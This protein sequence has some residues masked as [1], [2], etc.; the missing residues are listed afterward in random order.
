MKESILE[1]AR[2]WVIDADAPTLLDAAGSAAVLLVAAV[3][4]VGACVIGLLLF[5]REA[6]RVAEEL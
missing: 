5:E 2:I 6:P 3:I 1:Q 4:F